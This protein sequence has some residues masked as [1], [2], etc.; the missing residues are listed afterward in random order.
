MSI[1]ISYKSFAIALVLIG[2]FFTGYSLIKI[3]EHE[4]QKLNLGRVSLCLACALLSITTGITAY[5][6]TENKTQ[7]LPIQDLLQK[8]F[9]LGNYIGLVLYKRRE[10]A[11]EEPLIQEPIQKE[12]VNEEEKGIEMSLKTILGK[13]SP[14][15]LSR[16]LMMAE[17]S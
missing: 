6:W 2:V 1:T 15:R 9:M 12:L 10:N 7:S 17:S 13:L 3:S 14:N 11:R 8:K 4:L 16:A 5:M